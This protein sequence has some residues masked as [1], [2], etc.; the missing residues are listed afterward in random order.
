MFETKY[1]GPKFF[2]NII[3]FNTGGKPFGIELLC[4]VCVGERLCERERVG[5][6]E[7]L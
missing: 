7:V 6:P 2:K 3:H 1:F 4:C 5:F